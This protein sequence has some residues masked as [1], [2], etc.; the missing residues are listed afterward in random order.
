MPNW[1]FNSIGNYPKEVYEKY[2]SDD[3]ESD[4]DFNKIIPIPEEYNHTISGSINKD[5]KDIV[6]YREYYAKLKEELSTLENSDKILN[7]RLK[8]SFEN[9]LQETV[10]HMADM[11]AQNVGYL[12]IENPDKS[13]NTLLDEDDNKYVKRSY[14]NYV[15]VFGNT[16][17]VHSNNFEQVYDNYINLKNKDF[18]DTKNADY[19]KGVLDCYSDIEDY[20]RTLKTLKEKYGYE[21]WYDWSIGERQTKW[22]A[23]DTEY[24][25]ET[26]TIKFSTAWD[27]PYPVIAKIAENNP[28]VKLDGYSEEETGW[29]EEYKSDNGK[30]AVTAR[31]ELHWEEDSDETKEVREEIEDPKYLSYNEIR[32][33]SVKSHKIVTDAVG[34]I[35][36]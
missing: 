6:D 35:L 15:S 18:E 30:L 12:S 20:G 14:D 17:Y 29:F 28:E 31:G 10:R 11:T 2:K 16:S 21:D 9:P 5:A 7:D 19:N 34:R 23:S 36:K 8:Y 1:V 22:N 27:I 33:N 13:L 26:E 32:E 25:P 24:D 3:G 4:I